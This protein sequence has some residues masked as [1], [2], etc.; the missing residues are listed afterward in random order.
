MPQNWLGL[1]P[2]GVNKNWPGLA[3]G[4]ASS[5]FCD[6]FGRSVTGF[7]D[8]FGRSVTGAVT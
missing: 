5:I 6:C 2:Q 1:I 7:C 3:K 8:C 4:P